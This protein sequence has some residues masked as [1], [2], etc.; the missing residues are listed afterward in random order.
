MAELD[1]TQCSIDPATQEMLKKAQAEGIETIWDRAQAMKPCPIGAEGACCR[2][3]SQGPCRVPP[4]K[5]AKEGEPQKKQAVGL[6]GATAETIVARNFARMVC[7]GAAAHNDHSRGVA[8]LFKEV[9]HGEAPGYKIKD[10]AKLKQIARD[11]DVPLTEGEGDEAKARSTEVIAQELADKIMAEFGQQDGELVFRPS[12][13]PRSGWSSGAS[14]GSCPGAA[15][16]RSWNS[17][18]APTWGWTRNITT[19]S[20]SAPAPPCPTAGAAP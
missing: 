6:C 8:K 20:S 5:K 7:S 13:P 16:S 14:S 11:Y 10:V 18:T 15:T 17:C 3:C 2:I 1:V 9:A 19:S 4:P 12:G